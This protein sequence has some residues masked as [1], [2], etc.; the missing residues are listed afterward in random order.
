MAMSAGNLGMRAMYT[1]LFSSRLAFL[2]EI[3]FQNFNAP[4]VKYSQVF[5][6]QDSN[7]PYEEKTGITGF[8]MFGKKTEGE[9][10]DFDTRLQAYDKR[11]THEVWAKGYQFTMEM[12]RDDMDG[13]IRNTAP[14]LARAALST[15]ETDAFSDFNNAF[16]TLTTPDGGGTALLASHT[17]RQDGTFSNLLT[18]DISQTGIQNALDKFADM[19]DERNLIIRGEARQLLIPTALQW[20]THEIL[21]SQLRSDTANN[22]VNALNQVGLNVVVSP[23]LTDSNAWFVMSDPSQHQ[24]VYYWRDDPYTDSALDFD[25]RNMKTAMLF[26]MS[27][28]AFDWRNIV[29]SAGAS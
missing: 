4:D 5:N 12:M 2:N 28:G 26:S 6:V 13:I 15:I 20:V 14:E 25:T 10:I 17:L 16:G 1:D 8:G 3:L 7:M 11:L 9:K 24:L 18:G 29:G 23:Y 22:A 21:R 19:R 27:H